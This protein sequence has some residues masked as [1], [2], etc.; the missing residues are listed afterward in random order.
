MR[1][2]HVESNLVTRP[3]VLEGTE[4]LKDL[5]AVPARKPSSDNEVGGVIF[6]LG[7]CVLS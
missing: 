5:N 1:R 4:L 3:Q 2:A 6:K 7:A